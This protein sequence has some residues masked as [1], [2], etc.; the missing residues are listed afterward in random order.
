MWIARVRDRFQDVDAESHSMISTCA[1]SSS[2]DLKELERTRTQRRRSHGKDEDRSRD[3]RFE[4]N[5]VSVRGKENGWFRRCPVLVT[6]LVEHNVEMSLSPLETT[7]D[8][9]LEPK[10]CRG[11][12]AS[13]SSRAIVDSLTAETKVRQ[14]VEQRRKERKQKEVQ[15][16]RVRI[17][18]IASQVR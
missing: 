6:Q 10:V 15:N 11:V 4:E 3:R 13:I 1:T 5:Y 9:E 8:R 7:I 12:R 17:D 2:L 16:W 18:E 14:Q